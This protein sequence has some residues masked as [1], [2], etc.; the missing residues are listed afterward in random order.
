MVRL[1]RSL[2]CHLMLCGHFV[3][4]PLHSMT[5]LLQDDHKVQSEPALSLARNYSSGEALHRQR[6]RK[7]VVAAQLSPDDA[8]GW[9]TNSDHQDIGLLFYS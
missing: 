1:K 7:Q 4:Q 9:C 3:R 2:N 6:D 5:L 8:M